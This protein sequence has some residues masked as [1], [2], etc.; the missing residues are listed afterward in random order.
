M[1]PN[2]DVLTRIGALTLVIVAGP[3]MAH[4]GA[5]TSSG[6]LAGLQHPFS[7]LDHLAAM[8][9][10]GLIAGR[11]G[12]RAVISL[13]L[14]FIGMM[15]VGGMTGQAGITLTGIE[16]A[17]LL[18]VVVLAGMAITAPRLTSVLATPVIGIC[19]LLHGFAHGAAM[20]A[21]ASAGA[22]FLGFSLS[23]AVLHATG[24]VLGLVIA[25][26]LAAASPGSGRAARA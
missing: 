4:P 11:M 15:L 10:V 19:A 3:A 18:S 20:P 13:P 7:G 23:T 5:A 1:Q 9:A 26:A 8:L 22:Y 25:S 21:A 17:I 6:L 12:G 14:V 16:P 24:I 2:R